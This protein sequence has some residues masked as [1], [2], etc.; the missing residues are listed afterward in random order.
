MKYSHSLTHLNLKG[1]LQTLN[2][3]KG[4]IASVQGPVHKYRKSFIHFECLEKSDPVKVCVIYTPLNSSGNGHTPGKVQN[5][6][7]SLISACRC[8]MH[9]LCIKLVGDITSFPLQPGSKCRKII[10]PN[11]HPL[12]KRVKTG[13]VNEILYDIVLFFAALPFH[14]LAVQLHNTFKSLSSV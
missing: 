14:C 13:K 12:T 4:E 7:R 9:V 5:L 8:H 6:E 1:N 10:R 11:D 2:L 3:P